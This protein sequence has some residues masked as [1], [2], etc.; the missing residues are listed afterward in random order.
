MV[1]IS[2]RTDQVLCMLIPGPSLPFLRKRP[3][4]PTPAHPL[5][6]RFPLAQTRHQ[7]TRRQDEDPPRFLSNS[8]SHSRSDVESK[9]YP[10][11]ATLM[12]RLI[13]YIKLKSVSRA[14]FRCRI[15]IVIV[16]LLSDVTFTDRNGDNMRPVQLP[17]TK[18]V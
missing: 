12:T 14:L 11:L 4:L 18:D 9:R 3:F 5:S 17:T 7:T 6:F 13:P 1:C 15:Q 8:T 2:S 10:S 16:C